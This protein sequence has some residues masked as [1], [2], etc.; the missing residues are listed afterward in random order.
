MAKIQV[1]CPCC[2][3]AMAVDPETGAVISYDEKEKDLSSFEDLKSD[4]K[5]K[6][7]LRDQLF[8]Q[9][10]KAQKDRARLL[11]EKFQEAFK[12]ADTDSDEP[13]KNPLDFD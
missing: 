1:L 2:E 5:R 13:F 9:E 4:M 6:S 11:D 10:K 7:D 8:D 12:K 3:T